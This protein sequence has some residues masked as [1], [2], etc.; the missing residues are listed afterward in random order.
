M[1]IEPPFPLEVPVALPKSS[2]ITAR[3]GMPRA[4]A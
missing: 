3:A 1:C 4:S 2:A